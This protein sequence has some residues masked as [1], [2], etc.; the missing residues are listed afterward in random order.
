MDESI[1]KE[2]FY[3]YKY[4]TYYSKKSV[5]SY[6]LNKFI[7]EYEPLEE[8]Y[9]NAIDI[10]KNWDLGNQKTNRGAAIAQLTFDLTYD[11]DDFNYNFKKIINFSNLMFRPASP[12]TRGLVATRF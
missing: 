9:K 10:M 1:T 4:D 5:M 11:I 3:A 6:A 12:A 2:E 8:K 7:R